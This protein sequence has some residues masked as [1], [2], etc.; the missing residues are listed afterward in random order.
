MPEEYLINV[1]PHETRVAVVENGML[2]EII[3]ERRRKKGLVGN[4]YLGRVNRVLPGMQAAFVDIGLER[5]AFLHLSDLLNGSRPPGPVSPPADASPSIADLLA[6]GDE[7]LV[8]VTKDAL[9]GKG[10]RLA[11]RLSIASRYLV[12]LPG[13]PC[14]GVSQKITEEGERERLRQAVITQRPALA[15]PAEP[16]EPAPG[17]MGRERAVQRGPGGYIVRTAAQGLSEDKLVTDMDF[18]E[19]LW[20]TAA[21]QLPAVPC[22]GLVFEDLPVVLKTIRNLA[23]TE[24]ERVRIDSRETYEHVV[25]FAGRYMPDMCELIEHYT[26]ARPILELYSVE[27]EIQRALQ[28]RVELKSGGHLFIDQTEAMTT[29]D[30]NT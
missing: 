14:I 12:Y 16:A 24:V 30:V 11:A 19:R 4:I 6:S 20:Q 7:L 22:P 10:A 28:R 23:A 29:V 21:R 17:A 25:E 1:T 3:V 13:H 5:A 18:L 26:G 8:Q 2:Q 15:S 9:L 27:S